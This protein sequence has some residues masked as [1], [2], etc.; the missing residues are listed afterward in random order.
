MAN[1]F[2]KGS[3]PAENPVTP[4]CRK[5]RR[6]GRRLPYRETGVKPSKIG[7]GLEFPQF[8]FI[9]PAPILWKKGKYLPG[10]NF[11][12]LCRTA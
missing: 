6:K 9:R 5:A 2:F 1:F 11:P 3:L 10:T 4:H 7:V 12:C 8:R